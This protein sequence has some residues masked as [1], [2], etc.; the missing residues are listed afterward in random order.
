MHA[1]SRQ[2]DGRDSIEVYLAG[3]KYTLRHPL[4]LAA[5]PSPDST[6]RAEVQRLFASIQSVRQR[7]ID[8]L[9]LSVS[10]RTALRM[11]PQ[12]QLSLYAAASGLLIHEGKV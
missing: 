9:T 6:S 7:G 4:P 8:P 5:L 10:L 12:E 11:S 1:D 3:Q 2:N